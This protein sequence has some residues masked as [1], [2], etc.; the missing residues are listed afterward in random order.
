M[1][2][3]LSSNILRR[4]VI[5][6]DADNLVVPDCLQALEVPAKSGEGVTKM[7]CI[8]LALLLWL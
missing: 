6:E 1:K 2:L 8:I 5:S 4:E 7:C 3:L